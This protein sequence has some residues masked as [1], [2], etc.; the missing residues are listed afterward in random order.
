MAL[1]G[2]VTEK[3]IPVKT[4]FIL[5]AIFSL[6][7]FA[8][9]T[10]TAQNS[11]PPEVKALVTELRENLNPGELLQHSRRLSHINRGFTPNLQVAVM[12]FRQP[13]AE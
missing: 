5:S 7:T 13:F 4:T 1:P 3:E 9:P 12:P 11:V 8:A 10:G 2:L 6:G